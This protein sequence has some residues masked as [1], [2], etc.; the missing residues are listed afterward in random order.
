MSVL[1]SDKNWCLRLSSPPLIGWLSNV[2]SDDLITQFKMMSASPR[3]QI[4]LMDLLEVCICFVAVF[5]RLWLIG[6]DFNSLA[7]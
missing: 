4:F 7:D 2:L 3:F 5:M 1:G 6:D